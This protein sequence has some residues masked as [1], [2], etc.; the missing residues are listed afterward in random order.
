VHEVWSIHDVEPETLADVAA[1]LERITAAG[2]ASV[3]LLV[4]PGRDWHPEQ[5]ALLRQWHAQGHELAAHG[6]SHRATEERDL[7][8]RLHA[9]LISRDAAEHLSRSATEVE[10]RIR[11]GLEWFQRAGL[12]APTQYVPP[13]WAMGALVLRTLADT[14]LRTVETLAGL[15]DIQT[16]RRRWQ[17]LVGFEARNRLQAWTLWLS[18]RANDGLARW[19]GMPLR[20]AVHPGDARLLLAGDLSTWL[21]RRR[22]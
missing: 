17:G 5:I 11:R 7:R 19:L 10:S 22:T 18:N 14:S 2:V 20:V 8:H 16:G 6:W 3:T 15:Q 12:P 9:L 1:L 21:E 13:A 4:I